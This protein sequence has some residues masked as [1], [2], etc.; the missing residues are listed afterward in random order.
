MGEPVKGRSEA[1]R[2]RE[3]RARHTRRRII[4]AAL[5]LF[6]ERGYVATTIEA[7]AHDAGVAPAT[8]YQAFGNKQ[9]ILAAGLD[10]AVAGDHAPVAVL[11]RDWVHRARAESDPHRRL[12][13]VVKHAC[14]IAARTAP[15]KEVMRDAAAT[16]PAVG[17]LIRQDHERR[18]LTQQALVD[19]LIEQRRLRTGVDRR[20]AVDIFFTLVN[21]HTYQLMVNHLGRSERQ[22]REWL[23]RLL[24]EELFGDGGHA[25]R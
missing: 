7:I 5:R 11:A 15:L 13:T 20:R 12:A 9:K 22:W 4:D 16:E 23:V 17:D 8:I 18:Y 19:M 2:R 21:S 25:P 10:I 3:E 24:D 1:G 14:E 6:L